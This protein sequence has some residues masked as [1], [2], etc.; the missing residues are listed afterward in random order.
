MTGGIRQKWSECGGS[1]MKW[2]LLTLRLLDGNIAVFSERTDVAIGLR[3]CFYDR[4]F[5]LTNWMLTAFLR[6][7]CSSTLFVGH[8]KNLRILSVEW[9][10]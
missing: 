10:L 5:T 3:D 9:N 8:K 2:H 6:S 7:L 4:V 1:V